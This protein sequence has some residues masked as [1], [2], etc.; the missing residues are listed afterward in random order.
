MIEKE[1]VKEIIERFL[2]QSD[3]YLVDIAVK[4]GNLIV[5]EID[6]DQS[7][8]IDD[9]IALSRHIESHLDRDKEDFELEVGSS[10][11]GQPLKTLRQFRK[12]IGKEV[13]ILT[14]S[15]LK[16]EGL[17]K[18]ADEQ[19]I[20]LTVT[21]QVKP[22]GAKRKVTVEED[23]SYTYEELKYTKYLLRFR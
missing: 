23:L 11:I 14:R 1:V 4:P 13:E 22:E 5:V 12:Y 15:G 17:L 19:G 6:N 21:K 7:V 16:K 3:N 8:S 2:E 10:G 20:I 9:C 18:G